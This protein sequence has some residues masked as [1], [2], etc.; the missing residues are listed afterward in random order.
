MDLLMFV[1]DAERGIGKADEYVANYL[2]ESGEKVIAVINKI[3]LV[4]EKGKLTLIE[5]R[6]SK[7]CDNLVDVVTVSAITG[8]NLSLLVQ[9]IVDNLPEGPMY[10][11]EDMVTDRPLSF[12]VSEIIREK[13]LNLTYEEIPHSV[14]VIVEDMVERENGV[15]YVRANII[16]ERDSQKGIIIGKGGSMIKKIGTFA[17]E[18]IEFFTGKKVFLDLNVKVRKNWRN[19]DFTILNV[20]GLRKEMM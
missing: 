20:V 4:K 15:L 12:L 8:E 6:I 16:V 18:E 5:E 17:R 13:I 2:N 19:D 7:L 1:V 3:D 14:A 9:K 10:Y 11:P